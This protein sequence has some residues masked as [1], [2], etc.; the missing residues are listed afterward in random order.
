MIDAICLLLNRAPLDYARAAGMWV[1]N[2]RNREAATDIQVD[3]ASSSAVKCEPRS[4]ARK[5]RYTIM[6]LLLALIVGPLFIFG[7]YTI[8]TCI[9]SL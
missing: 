1:M 7:A 5:F 9:V 2:G 4:N 6:G 8:L 3:A